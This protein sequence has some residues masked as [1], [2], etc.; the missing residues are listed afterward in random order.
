M[1]YPGCVLNRVIAILFFLILLVVTGCQRERSFETTAAGN[2]NLSV[3]KSGAGI[4]NVTATGSVSGTS[5]LFLY[6]PADIVQ[7]RLHMAVI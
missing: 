2:S 3:N 4:V 7:M 6:P 1:L 5:K